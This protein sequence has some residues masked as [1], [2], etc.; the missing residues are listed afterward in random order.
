MTDLTARLTVTADAKQ[1]VSESRNAGTAVQRLVQETTGLSR[2]TRDAKAAAET[3]FPEI[4]NVRREVDQLRSSYE[5]GYAAQKRFEAG[6][7]TLNRAFDYG[8]V[9]IRQRDQLL[10]QLQTEYRRATVVQDQFAA[11]AV[12]TSS[13]LFRA[14]GGL[15][16][17]SYQIQDVIVQASMGTPVL[18]ALG[19]QAPQLLSGFG[20]LGA[21]FGVVAAVA[22]PLIATLTGVGTS[23]RQAGEDVQTTAEMI[24]DA[25]SAISTANSV[26]AANSLDSLDAIRE[27]YGAI[28]LEV[29]GLL[30]VQNELAMQSAISATQTALD[31]TFNSTALDDVRQRLDQ[32]QAIIDE[33]EN[34]ISAQTA[35]LPIVLDPAQVEREIALL[36]QDLQDTLDYEDFQLDFGIDPDT[37][38]E[39]L[40]LRSAIAD[41][42]A[43]ENFD[44]LA[45]VVTQL[46]EHLQDI[47]DGPLREMLEGVVGAE[48]AL[49]RALAASD[50][51]AEAQA[52][53]ASLLERSSDFAG[54]L[55]TKLGEAADRAELISEIDI[56]SGIDVAASAAARLAENLGVSL[57]VAQTIALA[58]ANSNTVT[59]FEPGDPR[60]PNGSSGVWTGGYSRTNPFATTTGGSGGGG[61]GGGRSGADRTITDIE[62]RIARLAG[63]YASDIEAA[64]EWREEALANLD[65]TAAGYDEFAG[66]VATIY[67]EMLAEAYAEDLERRTDWQAGIERGLQ[68]LA[69]NARTWASTIDEVLV[70]SIERGEDA[71]VEWVMTGRASLTDVVN[72]AI[73]EFARLAYQQA[74]QPALQGVFGLLSGSGGGGGIGGFLG[75]LFGGGTSLPT[76][77]SGSVM[78]QNTTSRTFTSLAAN[79]QLAVIKNGQSI[80]TP[81]HLENAGAIISALTSLAARPNEAPAGLN[82]TINQNGTPQQAEVQQDAQGNVEINFMDMIER[83]IAGRMSRSNTPIN[84]ALRQQ[85]VRP[86][87]GR[88]QA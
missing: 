21:V 37:L 10:E 28:T 20:A 49:L 59:G 11:S 61:G 82:L 80:F 48:D 67:D 75:R 47:P 29:L 26:L 8:E 76:S 14:G 87:Y 34:E 40:T 4:A 18:R 78:G 30:E 65:A 46:R 52:R 23:S 50:R 19:Q 38:Q 39:V 70:G 41:A 2:A 55:P 31:D 7:E 81:R 86:Q 68:E 25:L 24:E 1:V 72:F 66:H 63:S 64:N 33:L 85:G 69:E 45:I 12:R 5:P 3:F 71:W 53:I 44:E 16:N 6:M 62:R 56:A 17:A 32:R 73:E 27:R 77:H 9:N 42:L 22:F 51:T 74:I 58:G 57:Q 60:N 36:R 13:S 15:Q 35:T 79:E 54:N 83:E 43:A 84:R 88:G